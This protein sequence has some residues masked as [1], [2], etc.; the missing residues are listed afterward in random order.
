[1][2]AILV[3]ASCALEAESQETKVS[4]SPGE[5][6]AVIKKAIEETFPNGRITLIEKEVEGYRYE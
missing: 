1:L 4:V 2:S 5:L 3:V 6:P